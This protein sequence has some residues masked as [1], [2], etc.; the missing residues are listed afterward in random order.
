MWKLLVPVFCLVAST[1]SQPNYPYPSYPHQ[2]GSFGGGAGGFPGF[3]GGPMG[4]GSFGGSSTGQGSGQTSAQLDRVLNQLQSVF[5]NLERNGFFDQFSSMLGS[6]SS[7]FG[8]SGQA[9][10]GFAKQLTDQVRQALSP[11]G[12]GQKLTQTIGD[13][14]DKTG[15]LNGFADRLGQMTQT[16]SAASGGGR[17]AGGSRHPP[18]GY[19][20][21]NSREIAHDD[22]IQVNARAAD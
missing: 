5:G 14:I 13:A 21:V 6:A 10:T 17:A 3:Q 11:G 22:S 20:A 1:S 19:G 16:M 18:R 12:A 9:A 2:G 4:A 8:G 7:S 15:G